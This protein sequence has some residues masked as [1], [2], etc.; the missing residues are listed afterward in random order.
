M[1]NRGSAETCGQ[2]TNT[3]HI[4]HPSAR[5]DQ[6]ALELQRALPSFNR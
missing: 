4:K 3:R 5:F 1:E 2:N 6:N